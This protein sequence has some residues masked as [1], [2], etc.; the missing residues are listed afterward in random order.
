MLTIEAFEKLRERVEE[1]HRVKPIR[2]DELC[3][4]YM[5]ALNK[6]RDI[7]QSHEQDTQI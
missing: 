2:E 4:I 7:I 5:E 3:L 6:F 1:I